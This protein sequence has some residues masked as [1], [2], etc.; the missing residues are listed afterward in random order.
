MAEPETH[1]YK[2]LNGCD[3]SD[4]RGEDTGL[5]PFDVDGH[6]LTEEE[7]K[8]KACDLAMRLA[9]KGGYLVGAYRVAEVFVVQKLGGEL[10]DRM[11]DPLPQEVLPKAY[12]SCDEDLA[13]LP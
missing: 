11:G 2:F 7:A 12:R 9:P 13:P 3:G 8:E 10:V 4:L 5:G 6:G 1:D